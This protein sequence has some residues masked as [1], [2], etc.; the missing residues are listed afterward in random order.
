MRPI[1]FF[2]RWA[3]IVLVVGSLAAISA[4]QATPP[5]SPRMTPVPGTINTRNSPDDNNDPEAAK[6][7]AEQGMRRNTLRQQEIVDDTTKLLTLAQ[8]L[9][10]EVD[11][12]N[13]DMLS[14]AVVK[15]AEEIEKLAKIVKEKMRAGL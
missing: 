15:K 9:K 14:I 5:P 12:S 2:P 7:A 6:M 4:Q 1:N 11:K 8:Q 13:K 3:A 10:V